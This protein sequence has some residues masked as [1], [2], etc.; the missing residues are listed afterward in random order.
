MEKLR[1]LIAED[2]QIVREGLKALINAQ[3]D[4]TVVGGGGLCCGGD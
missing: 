3:P 4:M 1:I 2:H